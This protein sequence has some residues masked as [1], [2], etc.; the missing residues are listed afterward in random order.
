MFFINCSKPDTTRGSHTVI[1]PSGMVLATASSTISNW[2]LQLPIDGSGSEKVI[3]LHTPALRT[4]ARSGNVNPLREEMDARGYNTST[5]G[6]L[7][8]GHVSDY[9][10][11]GFAQQLQVEHYIIAM[12]HPDNYPDHFIVYNLNDESWTR[13]EE[14][15]HPM[16]HIQSN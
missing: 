11:I 12:Y 1:D 14:G 3:L 6:P 7:R 9:N 10:N 5:G 4:M 13:W 15:N 16:V 2:I 8:R